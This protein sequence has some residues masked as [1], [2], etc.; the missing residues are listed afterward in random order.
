MTKEAIDIQKEIEKYFTESAGFGRDKIQN[1]MDIVN[2]ALKQKGE[3][4]AE[5]DMK[6]K[7]ER[8]IFQGIVEKKNDQLTKATDLLKKVIKVTWGEGWNYSLDVKVE[9]EQFLKECEK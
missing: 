6:R 9:S 4:I 2:K 5:L 7:A 1:F 3:Q 8:K